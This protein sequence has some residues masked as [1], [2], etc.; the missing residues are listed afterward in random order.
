MPEQTSLDDYLRQLEVATRQ[1][2]AAQIAEVS[3]GY[4]NSDSNLLIGQYIYV[5]VKMPAFFLAFVFH[6]K[7]TTYVN[8]QTCAKNGWK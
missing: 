8:H 6:Q 3:T 4:E 7:L 1:Y 2:Q 5:S